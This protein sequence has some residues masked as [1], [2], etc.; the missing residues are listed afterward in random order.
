MT[1]M[2]ESNMQISFEWGD[3]N[4]FIEGQHSCKC[5]IGISQV[6]PRIKL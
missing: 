1:T 4:S 6:T 3:I 2:D 5:S